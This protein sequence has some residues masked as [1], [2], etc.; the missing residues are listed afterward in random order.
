[1]QPHLAFLIKLCTFFAMMPVLHSSPA[2]ESGN[3][4][5]LINSNVSIYTALLPEKFV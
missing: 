3:A 4:S 1:M 2:A 5:L